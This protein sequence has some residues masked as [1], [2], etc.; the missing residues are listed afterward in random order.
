MIEQDQKIIKQLKS[1]QSIS[2]EQLRAYIKRFSTNANLLM[3]AER[4]LKASQ[5]ASIR[6]RARQKLVDTIAQKRDIIIV[7]DV[8]HNHI[9]R[10][11][12]KTKRMKT[13]DCRMK[14]ARQ[15]KILL[16]GKVIV[17][18]FGLVGKKIIS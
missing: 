4:Q 8:R 18:R 13:R 10:I 5:T 3:I 7:N 11:Q 2:S 17:K 9:V 6:K 12:K 14:A 16:H 15:K 1:D